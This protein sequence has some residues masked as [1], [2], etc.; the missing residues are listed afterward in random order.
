MPS[1]SNG[2]PPG[3]YCP[4]CHI[5]NVYR[6]ENEA[7]SQKGVFSKTSKC[8]SCHASLLWQRELQF[9]DN[10]K[11]CGST[12]TLVSSEPPA[13]RNKGGAKPATK[14]G[15]VQTRKVVPLRQIYV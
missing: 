3:A 7:S 5:R 12:V 11:L 6:C 10:G 2:H 13:K 1:P 9:D 4:Y 8:E 15:Q 14:G